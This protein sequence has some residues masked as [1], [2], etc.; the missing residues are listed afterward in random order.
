[1]NFFFFLLFLFPEPWTAT[2]AHCTTVA[3]RKTYQNCMA[4]PT[5]QASIAWTF[6]PRNATLDLVFFGNFISPSGWVAWGINPTSPEMTGTRALVAFPDPNSGLVVLLPYILDPTVKLQRTPLLSRPLDIQL[7]SSSATLYGAGGGRMASIHNGASVQIYAT[8]KLVPNKTKIYHVWNRGLY[9]QGYSPTIH[10]TTVNDLSS[11]ATIDVLSGVVT[12]SS[13]NSIKTLKTVH[14]T[15]NA[16]SWGFLLPAGAVTARYFRHVQSLGPAWFYAHAGTQ[17]FAFVLGTIGFAI[18]IRLG[19]LS[20]GVVY[21]LHRKLGFAAF[22]LAGLQSLALL[23]RPK[24][25]HKFRKYW[26]SYHHFV[27]YACVVLGVVN[28]FQGFE[29]MGSSRSYA[30]LVYCLALSTLIGVCVALEVNGWVVFC[31][32]AKEEKMRR[33]G[34]VGAFDKGNGSNNNS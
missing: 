34:L 11:V 3:A 33:E 9:V 29:V 31:R 10:P 19:E 23:F 2:A 13:H 18:G 27:G 12:E 30:K 25:T 8:L 17:L 16:I 20:P 6:Y 4:L 14:A 28:V 15:L 26:K 21:G 7:L 32:K 24:A 5:Q 22:C 1:M